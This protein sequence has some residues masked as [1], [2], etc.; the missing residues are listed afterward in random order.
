MWSATNTFGARGGKMC[1]FG[2]EMWQC[3]TLDKWQDSV[4]VEGQCDLGRGGAEM[5]LGNDGLCRVDI[6]SGFR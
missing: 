3:L 1:Q 4:V 2:V 6:A 5:I